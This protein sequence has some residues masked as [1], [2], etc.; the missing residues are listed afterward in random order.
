MCTNVTLVQT[1]HRHMEKTAGE[2]RDWTDPSINQRM[3]TTNS[4]PKRLEESHG[5]DYSFHP[6]EETNHAD[7]LIS[8]V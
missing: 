6:Q 4:K 1:W 3:L 2:G 8:N 7:T 5:K